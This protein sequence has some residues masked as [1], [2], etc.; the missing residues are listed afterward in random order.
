MFKKILLAFLLLPSISFV[1]FSLQKKDLNVDTSHYKIAFLGDQGNG[2]DTQSVLDLV[3]KESASALL[4]L[5]DYDYE[6]KPDVWMK[7]LEDTLGRNFPLMFVIGNHEEENL[8]GYIGFIKKHLNETPEVVCV[9]DVPSKTFCRYKNFQVVITAPDIKGFTS[10]GKE[11]ASYITE[12]VSGMATSTNM[13][14]FCAWHKN[15][16]SMQV[17]DKKDEAGWEV[18]EACNKIGFPI[19]TGHEHSYSRSFVFSDI[20][21]QTLAQK[22]MSAVGKND[23][24][25]VPEK[26]IDELSVRQGQ[27]F[28]VV[29][30]LGGKSVRPQKHFEPWWSS[31]STLTQN[32]KAGALFCDFDERGSEK[33]LCYFKDINEN[34]VDAFYIKWNR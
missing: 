24:G 32:A 3:K 33:T 21:K 8:S 4:L 5:G 16:S 17:G 9:G 14:N 30:G 26:N 19:L 28:V 10:S 6:N 20:V 1:Y 11:Y 7:R 15:Q 13:F 27:T 18:Y 25:L 31:V 34:I 29:S 12:T 2:E 23:L 22:M